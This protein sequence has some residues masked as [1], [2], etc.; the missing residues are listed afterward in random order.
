MK[1]SLQLAAAP[2]CEIPTL[3]A[4]TQY[5]KTFMIAFAAKLLQ[6]FCK[7]SRHCLMHACIVSPWP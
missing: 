4:L 2:V 5:A 7:D 3:H 6:N 1:M